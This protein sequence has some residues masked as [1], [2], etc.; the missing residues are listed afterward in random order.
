VIQATRS[1]R[2]STFLIPAAQAS[3]GLAAGGLTAALVG[4]EEAAGVGLGAFVVALGFLVFGWRTTLRSPI[5]AA[6]RAFGRLILGSVL[7][8]LVIAAGLVFAMTASGFPP[9]FVLG[10]A[11]LACLAFFFCLPWLLR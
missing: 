4:M 10:G 1:A 2:R 6:E 5:V 11:L 8:W 7:K 9:N 3:L